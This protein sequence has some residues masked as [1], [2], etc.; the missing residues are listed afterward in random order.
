MTGS[1]PL[2]SICVLTYNRREKLNSILQFLK[3]EYF[4]LPDSS[5]VEII[6]SDNNSSD[7]TSTLVSEFIKEN[8]LTKWRYHKNKENIGL[9]GNLIE[10]Q[11]LSTG[12]YL[13]WWGDD[14]TYREG[15]LKAVLNHI[16]Q[17]PDYIFLNYTYSKYV[18]WDG[19]IMKS[20]L[21]KVNSVN[22]TIEGILSQGAGYIMFI[23]S[24]IYNQKRLEELNHIK[25]QKTMALPLLY[26]LCCAGSGKYIIDPEIW[27]DDNIKDTTWTDH[28][29]Q[30][31]YY[32]MPGYIKLM[33]QL[34]FN[35]R[36]SQDIYNKLYSNIWRKRIKYKLHKIINL[37][38][39]KKIISFAK[40]AIKP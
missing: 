18:P 29:A 35:E 37:L 21:D 16:E 30:I 25:Y 32:D 38:H 3:K 40:N 13:W 15:I 20:V 19:L 9:L 33:N 31:Y 17:Q 26:S 22:P 11:K 39:I 4:G 27:I 14:D 12:Q 34:G 5:I 6:I 8:K 28:Y 24:S 1:S 23:S 2:L 36:V 10:S 7:D